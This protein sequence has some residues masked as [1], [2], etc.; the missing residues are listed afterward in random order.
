MLKRLMGF[1]ALVV[2]LTAALGAGTVAQAQSER[3]EDAFP[4]YVSGGLGYL[5]FE[6]DEEVSDG[7]AAVGRWG[8]DWTEWIT[9]ETALHLAPYLKE[10]FY[11][12]TTVDANG[13]VTY[14]ELSRLEEATGDSSIDSTWAIGLSGDGLFHFTRWQRFDPYLAA[15]PSMIYYG[16]KFGKNQID[17]ALRAGAGAMYHFN[18]MWA[19]RA[20]WRSFIAGDDTEAN[21]LIDAGLVWYWGAKVPEKFVATTGP[22]D[23]DGDGLTDELEGEI[24]TN[25]YDPDTDKDRLTDGQEYLTH[26]TDPL[27]PDSDWDSL[28]DGDEVLDH[29]TDPLKRDTDNGGV[30]DGHEVIEDGTNP[31]NPADDLLLFELYIQFDYDKAILKS[32]YNDR[33]NIIAKVLRRH[34]DATARVEGHADKLKK[35]KAGYNK[36]LSQKRAQAVVDYLATK[37][38]IAASRM[39]SIGYGFDRP[40]AD[41]DPVN[42]NPVNRRVEV[43]IRGADELTKQEVRSEWQKLDEAGK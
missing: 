40:K 35:S 5:D 31:L 15:G 37:G 17:L 1:G 30:A 10:N 9:L 22:L 14:E 16:D 33:L 32:E 25:P 29:T 26:H 36:K 11:G 20:D 38:S 34:P 43:Y 28:K 21:S 13:V 41:N 2:F 12:R 18:D 19:L 4:Y 23:S 3:F 39:E 8:F 42:G 6:G 24:G 27:N 7:I